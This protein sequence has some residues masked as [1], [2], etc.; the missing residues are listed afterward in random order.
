MDTRRTIHG[1]ALI[2]ALITLA[3]ILVGLT[4]ALR[5]Q[6]GLLSASATAKAR[7]EALTLATAR[8]T[9]LGDQLTEAEY[10]D[11]LVP[12]HE[13]IPGQL[14]HYRLEWRVTAHGAPAYKRLTLD[15]RWPAADP[16]NA[17]TL[18]TLVPRP[19]LRRFARQQLRP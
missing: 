6:A 1:F 5:L 3:V 9:R 16:A 14:H 12:G 7:D 10:R 8:L 18:Q 17:I 2:E 15:V 13:E 11:L 19:D 4:G